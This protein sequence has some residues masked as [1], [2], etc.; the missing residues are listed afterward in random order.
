MEN[1]PSDLGVLGAKESELE[2]GDVWGDGDGDLVRRGRLGELE[3]LKDGVCAVDGVEEGGG[4]GTL[5][6]EGWGG[7]G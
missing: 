1:G 5:G 3:I 2:E 7:G 4:V 6:I